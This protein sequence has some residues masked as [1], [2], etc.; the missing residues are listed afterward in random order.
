MVLRLLTTAARICLRPRECGIRRH[1]YHALK[2]PRRTAGGTT[3]LG[4]P[5]L[6]LRLKREQRP[7]HPAPR[8]ATLMKRPLLGTGLRDYIPINPESQGGG[9][10]I[11]VHPF[12]LADAG[13]SGGEAPAWSEAECGEKCVL[14][15]RFAPS[16]ATLSSSRRASK[17]LKRQNG[18]SFLR[19]RG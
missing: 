3:R 6:R 11:S 10:P 17:A 2:C 1:G 14:G 18:L 4:P 12:V 16:G 8:L 19:R 5:L 7:P 13:T 9:L 15:F